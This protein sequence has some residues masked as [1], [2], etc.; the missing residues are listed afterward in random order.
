MSTA[1]AIHI[2]PSP[3]EFTGNFNSV[4]IKPGLRTMDYRLGIK[5]GLRYKTWT[6]HYG[7]GIKYGLG[8]KTQTE[9]YGLGIKHDE[10]Y[11]I[12]QITVH[13]GNCILAP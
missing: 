8:Y 12:P 1:T 4:S 9:H 11:K 10:R 3:T 6:K 13:Q 5:H 2:L 7:L